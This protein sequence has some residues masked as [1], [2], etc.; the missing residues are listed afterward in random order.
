MSRDMAIIVLVGAMFGA[1]IGWWTAPAVAYVQT[2]EDGS[3]RMGW[4]WP[5]DDRTCHAGI[6]WGA[7]DSPGDGVTVDGGC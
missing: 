1:I 7:G 2:W 4:T 3:G 5:S 6:V